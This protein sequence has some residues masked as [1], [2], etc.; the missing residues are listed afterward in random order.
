M[1]AFVASA[2]VF[3]PNFLH[4]RVLPRR[5][6]AVVATVNGFSAVRPDGEFL[7]RR[8]TGDVRALGYAPD[9]EAYATATTGEV[10]FYR[11]GFTTR[12]VACLPLEAADLEWR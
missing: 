8:S 6:E 2:S 11:S 4:L 9:E 7:G 10:C 3:A 5:R 12:N 1:A